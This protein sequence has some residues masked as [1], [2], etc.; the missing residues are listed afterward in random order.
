[1]KFDEAIKELLEG[2][3][4]E[5]PGVSDNYI[6][7]IEDGVITAPGIEYEDGLK[8]LTKEQLESDGWVVTY[9]L[10]H[11]VYF[12]NNDF[13]LVTSNNILYYSVI[14]S[15]WQQSAYGR[16]HFL[17]LYREG[18]IELK[19]EGKFDPDLCMVD[20]SPTFVQFET[21]EDAESA[22]KR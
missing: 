8:I 14:A 22:K 17:S 15:T 9:R 21:K 1:M 4:I 10:P 20:Y 6:L 3:E 12:F 19:F 5:L 13:Y 11:G 16:H 2:H 7:R 18:K